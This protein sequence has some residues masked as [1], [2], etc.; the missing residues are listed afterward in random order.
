MAAPRKRIWLAAVFLLAAYYAM[1]VGASRTRCN[2]FD[3][4]VHITAGYNAWSKHD[5]RFDPGNG[6]FVKR[7]ATV[8]LLVSRPS[9]PPLDSESWRT[10]VYFDFSRDLLYH[11]GNDPASLL[12][13][14]RSM[15][16]VLGVALGLIVF[17][18]SRSLFG[19]AGG[20]ISLALFVFCP[21]LLAHGANVSTDLALSL[22]LVAS[23]WFSWRLLHD[24][25]WF[26]LIASVGAF[27]LL[28][29]SKMT[30]VLIAPIVAVM[31]VARFF[32][33]EP[34]RWAI[35]RLGDLSTRRRQFGA[36]ASL[37]ALHGLCG[38][39][40]IW[41]FFEFKYSARGDVADTRLTLP[42][43]PEAGEVGSVIGG[44]TQFCYRTRILPEG[45]VNG[46]EQLLSIRNRRPSFL[47]GHWKAGG[48]TL[49]YPFAMAVKTPAGALGLL[50]L[51]AI[52]AV[53]LRRDSLR[54]PPSV[55]RHTLSAA[56]YQSVPLFALLAVTLAVTM[57]QGMNIGYRHILQVQPVL[58]ILAGYVS[59]AFP[60]RKRWL[61]V[62][63]VALLVSHAVESLS[64][65]PHY[66]AFVNRL[67]GGP[68]QGYRRLADS[69]LDWGQDLPEL[70]RWLERQPQPERERVYLA[71]FGTG[72]PEH[73]G[74]Q[75]LR[76]PGFPEWRPLS[77]YPLEPGTY[78]ISATQFQQLYTQTFGPWNHVYEDA[79]QNAIRQLGLTE[80]A[81]RSR[82]ALTAAL[83]QHPDERWQR[84][85]GDY[86]K[87]RFGRLCGWLRATGRKPDNHVGYSILIWKLSAADLKDALW[88]PPR[89][90]HPR[91]AHDEPDG[92]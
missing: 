67:A 12:L 80:A 85:Y 55:P 11:A 54:A 71:Y 70:K 14:T 57:R 24:V 51:G 68:E 83:L 72:I 37:L 38:W 8:P 36:A 84:L 75:T 28:V 20:F 92:I 19:T 18:W 15:V 90:L 63:T 34:W 17:L 91:P 7:W 78:A 65:H 29:V 53:S 66:F 50:L 52:A 33:S 88:G 87:L 41:T 1:A 4:I 32:N 27:S 77:V 46:M 60:T 44:F 82:D 56:L 79:Y 81:A 74:L 40:T 64:V 3:E 2:T 13:Q 61:E 59:L 86:E 5:Q 31:L 43:P 21:N 35:G 16:A 47:N 25:T 26:N 6:D 39:L 73:Y 23:T 62:A 58:Y 22:M 45:Y 9:Y 48:Q 76:L 69:S 30:A 89:E 42:R 49:F 10:A